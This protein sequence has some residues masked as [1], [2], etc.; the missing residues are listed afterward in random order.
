VGEGANTALAA[1]IIGE[2]TER[3]PEAA[4]IVADTSLKIHAI[5]QDRA[6][7]VARL[8]GSSLSV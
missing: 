4:G 1:E 6:N 2:R 3:D 8:R 5:R 7:R